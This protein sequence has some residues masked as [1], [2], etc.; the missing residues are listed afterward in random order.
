MK[1]LFIFSAIILLHFCQLSYA[2]E[3]KSSSQDSVYLVDFKFDKRDLKDILNE[4]AQLRGINILYSSTTQ[5]NAKVSFDAGKKITFMKAWEFLLMMLEQAGFSLINQGKDMYA[6][7]GSD[8]VGTTP[9]PIYIGTDT[10]EIPLSQ[11][12]I[13]YIYYFKNISLQNQQGDLSIILKNFFDQKN[14][15]QQLIFDTNFNAMIVTAKAEIIKAV[16]KFVDIFDQTGDR[17]IADVFDL[18]YASST[19][20]A[21]ILTDL[22]AGQEGAKSKGAQKPS[23]PSDT[24]SIFSTG[25]KVVS[26]FGGVSALGSSSASEYGNTL[27]ILGKKAEVEQVKKFIQDHLDVPLEQGK[28]FFHVVELQWLSASTLASILQ[29]LVTPP[30]GGG[31]STNVSLS[32]LAF[33]P[34]IK[35]VSESVSQGLGSSADL[36]QPLASGTANTVQRGSNK[37]I[38]AATNKDWMRIEEVIKKLDIPQK[39]VIIETLILDLSLVFTHKL[40]S[41]IRTNGLSTSVFP[42]TMQAQ[43]AML[44]PAITT[45]LDNAESI[46]SPGIGLEGDLSKILAVI[47][48]AGGDD[49]SVNSTIFMI[50]DKAS[51]NGVWAF[52][53]LLAL[54]AS[55]KTISR[56]FVVAQNNMPAVIGNSITKRLP[57]KL[58][59]GVTATISYQTVSAPVDI[60]FT[61][62]ISANDIV[63]LQM[64]VNATYWDNPTGPT[65]GTSSNRQIETNF[66]L[67]DG[68]VAILGGL[69]K[70]QIE[71]SFNGV[72]FLSKIPILGPLLFSNKKHTED[73]TKLFIVVRTTVT[74]PRMEGGMGKVTRRMANVA[75]HLLSI[76]E[77]DDELFS[78]IKDPISRWIFNDN[79]SAQLNDG[80]PLGDL[81]S[82]GHSIN[83]II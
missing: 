80:L 1:K 12:R 11:E 67:K 48:P 8:L 25:T 10:Q 78:S 64:Q 30:G 53:Q 74:K 20:V 63:N 21:K 37:L 32:N 38:I 69:T 13:R 52:F 55:S 50:G 7:I 82:R 51:S 18:K 16:M 72:P 35:I 66:S 4:F 29:E 81:F 14:V 68:Q 42:K 36:S 77:D 73:K 54:H 45:A 76:E 19:E 22:I 44:L 47:S 79:E 43:A 59:A 46:D 56:A 65:S 57:G 33:D 34:Q 5:L 60:S 3:S 2:Y 6:L 24:S 83:S 17:Q 75:N 39:Q 27:V 61:P 71:V 49:Q 40:A 23:N 58:T 26:L 41:Q 15:N 62:L 31:Q 28:S 9:L 70:N